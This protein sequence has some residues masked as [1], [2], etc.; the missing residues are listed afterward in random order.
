MTRRL[1]A[2]SLAMI[3]RL[4]TSVGTAR[5]S[6]SGP[7]MLLS[8]TRIMVLDAY[9]FGSRMP[10]TRATSAMPANTLA[11]STVRRRDSSIATGSNT[12]N[13]ELFSADQSWLLVTGRAPES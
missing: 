3:A 13:G 9:F 8:S 5:P 2:T 11:S 4:T 1:N 10:T 6:I 7:M 12:V